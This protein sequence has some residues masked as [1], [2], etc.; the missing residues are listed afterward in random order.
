[1][2]WDILRALRRKKRLWR[3]EGG[4]VSQKY[5]N[6]EKKVKNMIRNAKRNLEKRLVNNS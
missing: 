2:S 3:K 5:K 6:A 1:M 4:T